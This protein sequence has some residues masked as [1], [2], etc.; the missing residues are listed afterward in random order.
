MFSLKLYFTTE[1]NG[2]LRHVIPPSSS[3]P[4]DPTPPLEIM[5]LIISN[6]QHLR[7]IQHKLS[8]F[9][10]L[11]LRSFLKIILYIVLCKN[12]TP[13]PHCDPILPLG[14]MIWRNLKLH[15]LKI[16]PHMFQL[17][18]PIRFREDNFKRFFFAS[19]YSCVMIQHQM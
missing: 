2:Q 7:M 9:D 3:N 17:F 6:S 19:I 16:L 15:Y 1:P 8:F 11:F 13:I 14:V 4:C 5:I 18:W 10:Q 12:L